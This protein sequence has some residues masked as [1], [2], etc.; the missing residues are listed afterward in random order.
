MDSCIKN[1]MTLYI[2]FILSVEVNNDNI[3][4]YNNFSYKIWTGLNLNKIKK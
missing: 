4:I 1:K 3:T 2:L